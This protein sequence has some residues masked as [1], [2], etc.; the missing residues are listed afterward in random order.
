MNSSKK[1]RRLIV[2]GFLQKPVQHENEFHAND[3]TVDGDVQ[4]QQHKPKPN[5]A[6][7]DRQVISKQ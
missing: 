2:N 6:Q 5:E 1:A 3:A 4:Q 7:D